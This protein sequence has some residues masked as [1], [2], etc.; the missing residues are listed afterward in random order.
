[1]V[2]VGRKKMDIAEFGKIVLEQNPVSISNQAIGDV[3]RSYD[4]LKIFSK[5]KLIYGINTGFGPM[6]Q[7]RIEDADLRELQY[8]LVRSH[9]SGMGQLLSPVHARGLMLARLNTLLLGYSGIHP[10]TVKLLAELINNGAYPCIYAHGGVGASGD[11]VQLAHLALG[12]I[13]EG[14]FFFKGKITTAKNAYKI[15]KL[16]PLQI[17]IREGLSILNG[18]S[19]MTGIGGVNV[20]MAKRLVLWSML[21]SLMIN[22]MMEAYNDSFSAELNS[23]KL[24]AGQIAIAECM[25][26]LGAGSQLLRKRDEHLYDKKI[27]EDIID[28]KV[29]EYYSLRC[30][31]QILGPVLDTVRQAQQVIENELNSVNDNP[32]VDYKNKNV[33]HG[34]NFHG[35]YVSLEMDKLKLVITKLSMLAERQLNFLLN[36]H[37]NQK[38]P[39]FTNAGKP[40]LNFGLQG[41]Q[42]PATSTV[43]E[44]QA[45]SSSLYIHSIPNNND[46]QDIVSMGCNAAMMCSQVIENTHEVL[47]IELVAIMQAM[48]ILNI[49]DKLSPAGQWLYGNTRKLFPYF[50]TDFSPSH[51]LQV[52]KTWL[53]DTD[54]AEHFHNELNKIL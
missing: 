38:L 6:A 26:A 37:L 19:A 17:H 5:G 18:T 12:M 4:F 22:E 50:K 39:A 23:V 13:G 41:M 11:L 54:I 47:A 40:G 29:Q 34:G 33:F 36:P 7:Y 27:T 25:R 30:V 53:M 48:D 51:K 42:Y 2:S 1:M 24:H 15:M 10:D 45:L 32:V 28:D 46:N 35:D 52:V 43:A 16:A 21:L 3:K 9:S 20:I 44:N 49:S 31:P 8:N 14:N